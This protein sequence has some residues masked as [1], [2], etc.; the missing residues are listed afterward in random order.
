M[1][2]FIKTIINGVQSW[3]KGKIKELDNRYN[4]R[5]IESTA[6]WEQNDSSADNYVK[7]RTHW[8]EDAVINFLDNYFVNLTIPCDNYGVPEGW[9]YE[10]IDSP[11]D[12]DLLK[13]GEKYTI[14]LDN[15]EYEE[16]LRLEESGLCFGKELPYYFSGPD[17]PYGIVISS[18]NHLHLSAYGSGWHSFS[19]RGSGKLIHKLDSKYLPTNLATTDDVQEAVDGKMDANNPV[20]TGSFSM[21]RKADTTVGE[22]SN[23]IGHNAEASGYGSTAIGNVTASR[24]YTTVLGTF[25]IK[26]TDTY[27]TQGNTSDYDFHIRNIMSGTVY[28]V[29]TGYT[30]N[31]HT[32]TFNLHN[33]ELV[34]VN[35]SI[36]P[37]NSSFFGC[38]SSDD[39][40]NL[41]YIYSTDKIYWRS[42]S[43][44]YFFEAERRVSTTDTKMTRGKYALIVGNGVQYF[45]NLA[46][47]LRHI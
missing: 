19:I 20:G 5:I 37:Y 10:T 21:N 44:Y 43:G 13:V 1:Q 36:L 46:A 23:A 38:E 34:N 45:S 39:P 8:E 24:R 47:R 32:G 25:N 26:D 33:P 30:F 31:P 3:T 40:Q 41:T 16:T 35:D 17:V 18:H 9:Y 14:M 11:F 2:N 15:V 6:D 22:Y 42:Q 27:G 7:N 28:Y 4:K 12:T 29:G